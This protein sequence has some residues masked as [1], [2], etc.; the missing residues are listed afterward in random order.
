MSEEAIVLIAYLIF[1]LLIVWILVRNWEKENTDTTA[2]LSSLVKKFI[3]LEEQRAAKEQT[4]WK[5]PAST[6]E[7][8][9]E[10]EKK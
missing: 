9:L 10:K 4:L 7:S 8:D 1:M 5:V 6:I 2:E 3:E